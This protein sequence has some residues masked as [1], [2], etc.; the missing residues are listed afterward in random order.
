MC[1]APNLKKCLIYFGPHLQNGSPK[2]LDQQSNVTIPQVL[3]SKH[4]AQ[5]PLLVGSNFPYPLKEESL[6]H[7]LGVSDSQT[8]KLLRFAHGLPFDHV[9]FPFEPEST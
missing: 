8:T 6:I 9:I 1:L 3:S 2:S 4:I 5:R 7:H